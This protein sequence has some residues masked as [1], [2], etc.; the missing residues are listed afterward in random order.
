M[1][2]IFSITFVI[3]CFSGIGFWLTDVWALDISVNNRPSPS[4]LNTPNPSPTFTLSQKIVEGMALLKVSQPLE[5]ENKTIKNAKGKLVKTNELIRKQVALAVLNVA[6]GAVFEKRI[7]VNEKDIQNFKKTGMI[8]V[9]PAERDEPLNIQPKYWNSFNTYYQ[10]VNQPDLVVV[11]NKYLM[12]NKYLGNLP[13]KTKDKYTEIFYVPYSP[14]LHTSELIDAGRL[15]LKQNI[16]FAIDAL[17]LKKVYSR[18][19]PDQYATA[20]VSPDFLKNIILIEHIDPDQFSVAA[21]GGRELTEKVLVIIGANQSNAYRY[22]GS[23]AG[24]NGL[25]Q[26]I[27]STYRHMVQEYPA[28]KLNKDYI[29]GMAD[30]T[31]AMQAMVLFFDIHRKELENKIQKKEVVKQLGITEEMLAAAY[32]GGPGR[33]VKSVNKFGLAW[34]SQQFDLPKAKRVFRKETLNYLK[35]FQSIRTLDL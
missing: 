3:F 2:L 16:D 21:D 25:A 29:L 20:I 5:Y 34:L 33:V 4:P 1:K 35:K 18:S 8:T 23:P 17:N 26:F 31:N 24:A 11:G 30:H 32:N 27:K 7:W 28:A 9:A 10:V 12:P 15:Y 19:V 14:G 6:N 13:E 22:T